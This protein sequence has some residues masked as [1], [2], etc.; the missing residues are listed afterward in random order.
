[1]SEQSVFS[2]EKLYIKDLSVE[3]PHAPEIFLKQEAPEIN[4]QLHSKANQVEGN[5]FEVLLTIVVSAKVKE[6]N[7]FLVEVGQAGAFRIENVPQEQMEPLLAITCPSVLFPFAREVIA[8]ATVKAGFPPLLLQPVNFEAL[9]MERLEAE[10]KQ[11][12]E[13]NEKNEKNS[14][15]TVEKTTASNDEP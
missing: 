7:A 10:K 3:V 2:V 12:N 14:E 6:I 13:N 15:S 4:I 5:W 9:Y 11:K 8:N 1:M